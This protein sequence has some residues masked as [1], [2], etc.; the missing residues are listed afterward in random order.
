[1]DEGSCPQKSGNLVATSVCYLNKMS[2][3]TYVQ[4]GSPSRI[5]SSWIKK[6]P[7]EAMET[8]QRPNMYQICGGPA[9]LQNKV[10]H[11]RNKNNVNFAH[12]KP[13]YFSCRCSVY[14]K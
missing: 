4:I 6:G 5:V 1:M 14:L 9:P 10:S 11:L 3:M 8:H 2:Q 12:P 7:G 13:D